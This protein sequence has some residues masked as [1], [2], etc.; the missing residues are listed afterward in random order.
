MA[1]VDESTRAST[2]TGGEQP[3]PEPPEDDPE[4]PCDAADLDG[5]ADDSLEYNLN[6]FLKQLIE[7]DTMSGPELT[8]IAEDIPLPS[9]GNART[10]SVGEAIEVIRFKD[11][12]YVSYI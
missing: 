9:D 3:A 8:S 2:P 7:L 1:L 10:F 11:D 5:S 4:D 12:L 6:E